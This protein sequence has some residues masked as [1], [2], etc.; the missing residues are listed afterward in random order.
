M[1][2]EKGFNTDHMMIVRDQKD[3]ALFFKVTTVL[4]F[5]FLKATIT[6][7]Y[8]N[9]GETSVAYENGRCYK[10]GTASN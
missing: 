10:H 2:L 5:F 3:W 9:S 7:E 6:M 8:R 4:S 1:G